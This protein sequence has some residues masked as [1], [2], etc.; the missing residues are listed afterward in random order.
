MNGLVTQFGF[1]RELQIPFNLPQA[2]LQPNTAE[3]VA[4][5]TLAPGQNLQ[6]RWLSVHLVKLN[7]QPFIAPT[8]VNPSLGTVYAGLVG[9]RAA[10][11][12]APSGRPLVYVPV[13][14]PGVAANPP[15]FITELNPGTY[16]LIVVNNLLETT[17]EVSC[18]GAFRVTLNS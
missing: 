4:I 1:D 9:D 17:V 18:C 15:A 16:S 5:L 2:T 12:T 7:I 8:K 14:L 3:Q 13:E 11:L 10:F 6:L